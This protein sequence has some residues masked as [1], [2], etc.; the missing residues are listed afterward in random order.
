[1]TQRV[2]HVACAA[3]EAY[4]PHA[5]AMLY[6]VLAHRGEASVHVHVLHGPG[7]SPEAAARVRAFV[8]RDGGELS[9]H[10]VEDSEVRGLPVRASFTSAIWY[11]ILLPERLPDTDRVLYLDADT[12]VVAALGPLLEL[13]LADRYVAAVTN[14]FMPHQTYRPTALG[15]DPE[16]PYFNSG[17]LVMNLDLLRR[18]G[19][20]EALAAFARARGDELEWPDQDA[21]NV[22]LGARRLPLH[23]RWN[24]MNSV[25][26]FRRARE[27]LGARAVAEAR[28]TPAIRH[29]EGPGANKPWHAGAPAA[30]RA[31]YAAQRR[32]TPWPDV[33]LEGEAAAEGRIRRLVRRAGRPRISA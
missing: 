23:P 4:A 30:D 8:E 26:R 9:L 19:C 1:M 12:I 11:R 7:L 28:R 3:D 27:V 21:L 31:L 22:V 15:L 29:F 2:L 20:T 33:V 18:E 13:D 24:A 16:H 32:G 14:V 5:A 25:L 10:R 6:S 17:V